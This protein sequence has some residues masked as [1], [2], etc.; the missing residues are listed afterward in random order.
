MKVLEV[1]L[2]D[3]GLTVTGFSLFNEGV[4]I[5]VPL[6]AQQISKSSKKKFPFTF[7]P[8]LVITEHADQCYKSPVLFSGN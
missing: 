2:N 1:T 4:R 6:S 5:F 3:L 8:L 7:L